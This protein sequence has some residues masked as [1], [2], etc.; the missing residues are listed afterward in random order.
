MA[1]RHRGGGHGRAGPGPTAQREEEGCGREGGRRSRRDGGRRAA[2]APTDEPVAGGRAGAAGSS[3]LD[4]ASR[5]S[6]RAINVDSTPWPRPPPPSWPPAAA[7]R[8]RRRRRRA[9]SP[10]Y[11][12][13]PGAAAAAAAKSSAADWPLAAAPA[14]KCSP[15]LGAPRA[16]RRKRLVSL[17]R[18]G[19]GVGVGGARNASRPAESRREVRPQAIRAE[20]QEDA[21]R[22]PSEKQNKTRG[23][24]G[25]WA[26]EAKVCSCVFLDA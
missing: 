16:E 4:A 5:A 18:G 6:P 7:A 14:G 11:S 10:P 13:S 20:R 19:A 23:R 9:Q 12:D 3:V 17:W 8:S 24:G 26:C 25:G 21:M 22:R 15:G 1:G 2:A